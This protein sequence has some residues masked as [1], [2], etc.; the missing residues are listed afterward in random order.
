MGGGTTLAIKGANLGATT[1]VTFDGV[2]AALVGQP[3]WNAIKV[4]T[5]QAAKPGPVVVAANGGGLSASLPDAFTYL[6]G[7]PGA[8]TGVSGR[9]GNGRATVVWTPPGATGGVPVRDFTVTAT[10]GGTPCVTSGTSCD[11]TGLTNGQQ[12]R[13]T[14]TTTNTAGLS[15][16]SEP[17]PEVTPYVPIK[18]KVKARSARSKLPRK[19]SATAVNW[20]KRP[21][22]AKPTLVSATCT[23]G[24]ARASAE[25][26]TF[27]LYKTGK[28]KVR[29]KGVRGVRVRIELQSVPTSRAPAQYGP[30]AI[31]SRTW[32]VR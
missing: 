19:G 20:V 14:V 30:S 18:Q 11:V 5:P 27:K 24:T 32:T 13:F 10:T 22:Y 23:D 25:L 6:P 17:S 9:P 2:T 3:T 1:Q 28:V 31:W 12:Y 21:S 8:A 4:A 26:C 16:V 7:A 29:T 15:S